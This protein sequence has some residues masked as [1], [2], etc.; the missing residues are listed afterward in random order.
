[1]DVHVR[2]IRSK[3]GHELAACMKTIRNVGYLFEP[4]A[5]A[6]AGL[7]RRAA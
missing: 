7:D 4:T 2:R 3:L 1:V 5:A 6:D